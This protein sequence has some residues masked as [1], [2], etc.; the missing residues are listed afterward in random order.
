M[1]SFAIQTDDA[2]RLMDDEFKVNLEKTLYLNCEGERFTFF[3]WFNDT[4]TKPRVK[5]K[6]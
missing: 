6:D 3:Q 1:Y 2:K 4:V 5:Y